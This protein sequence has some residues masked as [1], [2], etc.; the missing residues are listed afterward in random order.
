M[1]GLGP[2]TGD[3]YTTGRAFATSDGHVKHISG[4]PDV[5]RRSAAADGPTTDQLATPP[6]AQ[7]SRF[8]PIHI[9]FSTVQRRYR[10]RCTTRIGQTTISEHRR[11]DRG[12]KCRMLTF[13]MI[14]LDAEPLPRAPTPLQSVSPRTPANT[15]RAACVLDP[16]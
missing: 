1:T 6:N 2:V 3:R 8:A 7:R 4:W 10:R 16:L 5:H 14:T 15:L 13:V 12:R 11:D 9:G